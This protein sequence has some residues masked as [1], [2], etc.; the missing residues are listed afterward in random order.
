M[1]N[2]HFRCRHNAPSTQTT[3]DI[4]KHC[5]AQAP[6]FALRLHQRQDVPLA[7]RALHVAHDLAVLVVKELN[8]NLSNLL[9]G[10]GEEVSGLF[11]F[12]LSVGTMGMPHDPMR[13]RL[14]RRFSSMRCVPAG[15][16]C[17]RRDVCFSD[18]TYLTAGA[19]ASNH[20][21]NDGTVREGGSKGQRVH[22]G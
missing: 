8:T 7:H 12:S 5:L 13:E 21:H 3:P 19:G 1:F 4:S 9:E 10:G 18:N 11:V 6:G 22:V 17:V 15:R 16:A 2:D 14:L 20:F